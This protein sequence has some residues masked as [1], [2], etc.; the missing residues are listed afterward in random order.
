MA[1]RLFVPGACALLFLLMAPGRSAAEEAL[2]IKKC[3]QVVVLVEDHKTEATGV[4]VAELVCEKAMRLAPMFG[5]N[6]GQLVWVHMAASGLSFNRLTGQS[7]Y[8][9][10]VYMARGIGDK[11]I[12]QPADVLNKNDRLEGVLTHELIHLMVRRSVGRRCPTWLNE[13]LAQYYEGR[14]AKGDMPAD[15]QELM[16]LEARWHDASTPIVQKR[17]D[18]RQSLALVCLLMDRVGEKALLE[19]VRKLRRTRKVLEADIDGR[20]LSM[21]LF[22]DREKTADQS[23]IEVQHGH[24]LDRS[25]HRPAKDDASGMSKLPLSEMLKRAKQKQKNKKK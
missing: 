18:Y 16:S 3:R 14:R 8:T 17:V 21:W 23:P 7:H 2:Q 11:I 13:G 20:S 5:L 24:G 15:E 12:T 19:M 10:A 1:N 9:V 4:R 25:G 22:R 6:R